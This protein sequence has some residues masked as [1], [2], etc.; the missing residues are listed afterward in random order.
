[1]NHSAAA[2]DFTEPAVAIQELRNVRPVKSILMVGGRTSAVVAILD[3]LQPYQ[4]VVDGGASIHGTPLRDNCFDVEAGSMTV[5]GLTG[6]P[7]QCDLKGKIRILPPG[8]PAIIIRDVYISSS[9]PCTFVSESALTESGCCITK[10]GKGGVVADYKD[11]TLFQLRCSGGLYF[12]EVKIDACPQPPFNQKPVLGVPFGRALAPDAQGQRPGLARSTLSQDDV[13]S[14]DDCD[15][16]EGV[17]NVAKSYAAKERVDQLTLAHRRL[18][19]MSFKRVASTFG[20]T[21]PPDYVFPLCDAC[22]IGKAADHPHHKGAKIRATRKCEGLHLDFCGPF[23]D[24]AITGDRYL[25]IF[26]CDFTEFI[27]DFYV[28]KQSQFVDI[29]DRF[30]LRLDSEHGKNCVA[31]IRSDNGKVFSDHRVIS[32]C[33]GRGI[34]N[35]YSAP[36]SQWQN[37][38]A[39]RAFNSLLDLATPALHQSGLAPTYWPFAIRLATLA[40]TRAR[41][42]PAKNVEKGFPASYSKMERLLDREVPTQLNGIYAL[43]VL[44]YKKIP[45]VL[46]KKFEPKAEACLYLGLHGSI[47]GALLLPLAGGRMTVSAVFTVNE[48]HLPLKL[49]TVATANAQFIRLHGSTEVSSLPI[50]WPAAEMKADPALR[51]PRMF[52]PAQPAQLSAGQRQPRDRAPSARCLENIVSEAD[53]LDRRLGAGAEKEVLIFSPVAPHQLPDE[54]DG[55][56]GFR[57]GRGAFRPRAGRVLVV[58]PPSRPTTRQEFQSATPSTTRQADASEHARFWSWARKKEVVSHIKN[59]TFGPLL[60]APPAGFKPINTSFVYKQR[61]TG[62]E[63]VLPEDLPAA[64]WKGRVVVKGYT[65]VEGRDYHE[66]FAPT[67]A[68]SSVRL[69][70]A[71]STH[72]RYPVKAADFE[73]AFLNSEMDTEVY[74][75]TPSG[76]ETWAK[77]GLEEL[78]A[79]PADFLPDKQAEPVGCRQLLKGVPGIKQGS[80]LFYLKLKKFLLDNGYTQLPADPCVYYRVTEKGLSLLAVWVDDVLAMVPTEMEWDAFV[81]LVRGQFSLTD[82][83]DVSEFLGMDIKQS[84]DRSKISLSQRKSIGDLLQRAGMV[85]CNPAVTPGVAGFVWTKRDCPEVARACHP[86]MPNYRGLVALCLFLSVWTRL[87]IVFVV[88]KLCKFMASPGDNHVAALKR[89]CRYLAGTADKGLVYEAGQMRLHGFTDSSHMDCPDTSRSTIAFLFFFG[90][91]PISWYSK[92]HTYVTTCTNH[93][94]YAALFAAAKEAFYLVGWLKPLEKFLAFALEPVP[95]FND[96]HGASALAMDPVGR[97]K[98]KH[99]LM[100]HHYTQELVSAGLILPVPIAS[101]ENVVDM[102]TKA[103]GPTQFPP[104]AAKIVKACLEIGP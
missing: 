70:A 33:A 49:D 29:L 90:D 2:A 82:K 92:L 48:G 97:F 31:W 46:R 85:D 44:A 52:S 96:N 94:E 91:G 1:M 12:A 21:L 8:L 4:V 18:S 88:N 45:A 80:R 87:D 68:P 54:D 43:G 89:L 73:T 69:I 23:P 66:T 13:S 72:L 75:S 11:K 39:E 25:L 102:L 22:V 79:M 84:A 101:G 34:R 62:D 65:M 38:K 24:V 103:L 99:V 95:I 10:K 27:W 19:H 28:A 93:S 32:I 16:T 30:L 100:A 61:Y 53:D 14:G 7:F 36:Y 40:L 77:F 67:A 20:F 76:Y 104:H 74:I 81:E 5:S 55:L 35:E 64:D 60:E 6:A 63:A 51:D 56:E 59:K 78:L 86:A 15:M 26:L 37:G 50:H 47:K 57:R 83:G 41:A 98:N 9:F 71:L 3:G 58:S 42:D 17:L